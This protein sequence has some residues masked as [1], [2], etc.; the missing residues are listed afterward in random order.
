MED[1]APALAA[2]VIWAYASIAY[3]DFMVGLGVIRL[4]V[5]RMIYASL[6]LLVPPSL[7]LGIT[8]AAAYGAV[9]GVL[10]LALGDSL[11]LRGI[12]AAGVSTALPPAAYSYIV[13]EQFVAVPPLGGAPPQ[14]RLPRRR[15]PRADRR[16]PPCGPG[17]E[18][19]G[20][21]AR[22]SAW[23]TRSPPRLLGPWGGTPLSGWPGCMA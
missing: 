10:S 5:L 6:A 19:W 1:L 8:P 13:M 20:G 9:S 17:R 12:K 16:L 21:A 7:V 2:A 3:R 4:N 22:L 23:P 11:Y 14:A 15:R 18:R